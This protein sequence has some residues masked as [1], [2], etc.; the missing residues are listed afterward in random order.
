[1]P[2]SLIAFIL[3]FLTG[4][5]FRSL[6]ILNKSH[7]ERLASIVFS[8]SLPA[9]ILVS[10]D[11]VP[12][13]PTAWKLP[14]AAALVTLPMVLIVFPLARLL[15]L[16]RPTEGGFLIASG[17]INSIYFAYPVILATL[18]DVALVQAILFDLGQTTLTLTL[19]YA[20]AV[21][22]GTATATSA[23]RSRTA[24]RRFLSAPPLW[25]LACV[26]TLK[27]LGVRLPSWLRELLLPLHLTTTPLAS[28]VLGLSISLSAVRHLLPLA[29]LG[30][31]VRMGGG[32]LLGFAGAYLLN[33]TG[34]ERVVVMLVAGM[35]SAVTAVI[36]ASETG[37]NEDLVASIV[38]LS[39]CL[40]VALLPWLPQLAMLL[41]GS[42]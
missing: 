1:M 8:F 17:C 39:I 24:L 14:A 4:A 20:L 35:P 16:P 36:F 12:F 42:E 11:G 34:I 26:L 37:L 31:V 22:Y 41:M 40:G 13:T 32:I 27:F 33:L 21:W 5:L 29:L 2:P 38:A 18:G 19:L 28:L 6:N 23:S 7:A 25:A 10:L 30:V 3:I 9:T 15:H